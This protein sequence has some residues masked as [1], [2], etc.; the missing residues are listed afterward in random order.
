M[1][2]YKRVDEGNQALGGEAT[3]WLEVNEAGH[4]ERQ[5]EEYPNGRV[6]SYDA[7][8]PSDAFGAL[9]VMVVDDD[10]EGWA[11]FAIAKEAFDQRWRTH[12]PQNR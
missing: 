2:Y 1:R 4:A 6:V 12:S 8:H 3:Y 7:S 5:I 11:E 10:E 9:A